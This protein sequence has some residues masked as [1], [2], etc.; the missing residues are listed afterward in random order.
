MQ[1]HRTNTYSSHPNSH[2]RTLI[3][4][5]HI[6]LVPSVSIFGSPRSTPI[7]RRQICGCCGKLKTGDQD[8]RP[9]YETHYGLLLMSLTVITGLL[10]FITP[11]PKGMQLLLMPVF[12]DFQRPS[13]PTSQSEPQYQTSSLH[14]DHHNTLVHIHTGLHTNSHFSQT[15]DIISIR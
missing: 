11:T 3:T 13:T 1:T 10:D 15:Y 6:L 8:S 5:D 14:F 4:T 2:P 7:L 12:T 9:Q